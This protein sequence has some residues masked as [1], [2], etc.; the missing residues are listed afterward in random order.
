MLNKFESG[1]LK[2]ATEM[3]RICL[4]TLLLVVFGTGGSVRAEPISDH[5]FE[6][7]IDHGLDYADPAN[8]N[9]TSYEFF[10]EIATDDTVEFIEILAPGGE[11]FTIPRLADQWDGINEIWTHWEYDAGSDSY[12]W[13]YEATYTDIS[14][15]DVYGD[16][17]YVFNI[18]YFSGSE[19]QTNVWYG[20]P[21]TTDPIVQPIQEPVLTYPSHGAVD[22][23]SPVTITWEEITDPGAVGIFLFLE[24][25]GGPEQDYDFDLSETNS[26]PIVLANGLWNAEFGFGPWY[27]TADNG[28]GIGVGV[29]KYA[30]SD[31]EFTVG[32]SAGT[33][34]GGDGSEGNPYLINSAS[35]MQ[36]IGANSDDWDKHFLVTANIDLGEFTDE[37]FN[38]IGN[39]A[40][41]FTGV[42]NAND[43]VISN[44]TYTSTDTDYIGL[45]GCVG[46][47]GE[48]KDLGLTDPNVDAG[49]GD[50]VGGLVGYNYG[51][52]S[53]CYASG[54]VT[55]TDYHVGGLV[56]RNDGTVSNCYATGTVTGIVYVG[57]L[58][59]YNDDAGTV[60]NSYATGDVAGESYH[61]GG[62]M[63]LNFGGISNC[64]ASGTVTGTDD[65]YHVGGLVGRNY[66]TVENSYAKGLVTGN[67]YVGGL[68]AYNDDAGKVKNSYATGDVEGEDYHAGG[69]VGY[70]DSMISNCYSTGNVNGTYYVGGFVGYND[71]AGWVS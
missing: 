31:Y 37:Q 41:S 1:F 44:F 54:A 46:S 51:T 66:G 22:V 40:D 33:Y 48:I 34:S 30:E 56:G 15:F 55:G 64:Y 68:V 27:E 23:V 11:T 59:G 53:N 32:P 45:F 58:V 65:H 5:V 38:I 62:L 29:G 16:G 6:V 52:V 42:F 60:S 36:E 57:G 39:Y 70:N 67:N 4:I 50:N 49:T 12:R 10:V 25:S 35:D 3:K 2:S 21:G 18:Y 14:D 17:T 69:L 43:H 63:G 61:V 47:A 28:D 71:G 26:D 7:E 19:H 24:T 13:E 9:D 20:I 8:A